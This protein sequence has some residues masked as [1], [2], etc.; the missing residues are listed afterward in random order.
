M[1][2]AAPFLVRGFMFEPPHEKIFGRKRYFQMKPY[3]IRIQISQ[4][5]M[6]I[7]D[8]EWKIKKQKWHKDNLGQI[9]V[10]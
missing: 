4:T 3:P 8:I 7:P 9:S 1:D 6:R 2:R 10:A 5:V